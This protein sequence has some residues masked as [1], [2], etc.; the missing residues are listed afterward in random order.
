MNVKIVRTYWELQ[1]CMEAIEKNMKQQH[2]TETKANY[3]ESYYGNMR[4]TISKIDEL[5]NTADSHI[6]PILDEIK[7][8]KKWSSVVDRRDTMDS[9]RKMIERYLS[10]KRKD[11]TD[12]APTGSVCAICILRS[13]G[14]SFP[15]IR[16]EIFGNK[17][18]KSS[19]AIRFNYNK[20]KNKNNA[21][22][23]CPFLSH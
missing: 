15:D 5:V 23:G 4:A 9:I 16:A 17:K 20:N 13:F 22:N 19:N 14:L 6:K 11:F 3:I 7:K 10:K 21:C 12:F 1:L 8:G 2:L 18:I